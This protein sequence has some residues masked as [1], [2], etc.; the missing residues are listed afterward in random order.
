M[1]LKSSS[2]N[3]QQ[4]K[5]HIEKVKEGLNLHQ[6]LDH[7]YV[8]LVNHMGSDLTVVNAARVSYAKAILELSRPL[9]PVA[10]EELVPG[11]RT[12]QES[13]GDAE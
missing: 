9:F 4:T 8:R 1:Q 12:V 11:A 13:V 3:G 6:V 7:G 10:L 2:A 5:R